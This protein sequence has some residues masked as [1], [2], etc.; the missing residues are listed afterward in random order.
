[1]S[2]NVRFHVSLADPAAHLFQ[3]SCRLAEPNPAGQVFSLPAWIPGSYMIRD[4]A[5]NIV[6]ISAKSLTADDIQPVA[7]RKTDKQTWVCEPAAG[8]LLVR[9]SVYAWDLSVRSA[10]FDQTHAFLNGS[11]LFLCPKGF[12]TAEYSVEFEPGKD[13]VGEPMADWRI[14]TAMRAEGEQG[15][16]GDYLADDYDELIDHPVEIGRQRVLRF[17]ACGVP[18]ELAISG[19]LF[20]D[21]DF[22]RL[23][24]DLQLICEH[25]IRFFGEPAPM[26]R[27]VFLLAVVGDGYGG[28]EHRASSANMCKRDDLPREHQSDVSDGYR[29]LLGLLSHEYF[30]TWNVKRIKP[31]AFTPYDLRSE[32]H[33]QLLWAFEGITSYFDDQALVHT[34]LISK[35]SYLT[36]LEQIM[37]Q[38]HRG[39]GRLKQTVLESSFDAWSKFYKQDENAANA[40]VSYYTKGSLIALG[41]DLTLRKH[42]DGAVSLEDVMHELWEHYGKTGR[43]V[44]EDFETGFDGIQRVAQDLSDLDLQPFFDQALRSTED[45]PLIEWLADFGVTL[46]WRQNYGAG[47]RGGKRSETTAKATLGALVTDNSGEAKL[48]AVFDGGNA[49]KAGLSAGDVVIAVDDLRVTAANLETRIASYALGTELSI[50]AFRRDELM[51]FELSLEAPQ[52]D[53]AVLTL[54]EEPDEQTLARRT[55]WLGS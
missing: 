50:T 11:S 32:S 12:E 23:R 45:L 19:R 35:E 39:S 6:E 46:N 5:K 15:A 22:E 2:S 20:S 7:I 25:H 28:L 55:A 27:Y 47:D 18:H 10:H 49:R 29:Q 38:V 41:L 1:M 9:Y 21:T 42:T 30:H 8:E 4:F 26:D 33:T 36:L 48:A 53:T 43:G 44:E 13:A 16:F 40:I 31:A 54:V 17:E 34:G 24:C 14:S 37:T 51:R 52:D 3:V